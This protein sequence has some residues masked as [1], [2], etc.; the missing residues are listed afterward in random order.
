MPVTLTKKLFNE[1]KVRV[2]ACVYQPT[3][4]FLT[5]LKD[6]HTTCLAFAVSP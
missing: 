5:V 1:S 3:V 6:I 4:E 2:I